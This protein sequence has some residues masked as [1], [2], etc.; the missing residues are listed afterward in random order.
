MQNSLQMLLSTL[1]TPHR[2]HPPP[3]TP[4]LSVQHTRY[5]IYQLL[6]ALNYLG[7]AGIVHGNVHPSAILVNA[8][9]TLKI[10]FFADAKPGIDKKTLRASYSLMSDT[11]GIDPWVKSPQELVEDERRALEVVMGDPTMVWYNSP[12]VLLGSPQKV[13]ISRFGIISNQKAQTNRSLS[14]PV[15]D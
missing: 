11:G 15:V 7:S 9:S 13:C 5:L 6:C 10:A 12:E 14:F 4:T 3:H 8:D 1:H 2:S